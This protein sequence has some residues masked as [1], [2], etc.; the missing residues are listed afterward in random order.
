MSFSNSTKVELSKWKVKSKVEALME[1][2]AIS[3]MNA[4]ITLTNQGVAIRFV[5]ENREVANRISYLIYQI[6]DYSTGLIAKMNDQLQKKPV[7]YVGIEDP[8]VATRFL[9]EAGMNL[10]GKFTARKEV[11]LS[12]IGAEEKAR[13]YLRGAFLGGGSVTNPE[14]GYHLEMVVNDPLDAEILS[15]VARQ[16]GL[17]PKESRRKEMYLVYFK[18]AES[19][20]DFLYIVGATNALL[21]MED[22]R[23]MKNLINDV[24]RR[25]NCDTANLTKAVEASLKHRQAIR[26]IRKSGAFDGL[27]DHLKEIAILREQ[28]PEESLKQLGQHM[29][30]VLGKSGVRNRLNKLMEIA[31]KL[32][33]GQK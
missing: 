8:D 10:Y 20:V 4:T 33:E 14:K 9:E 24:N 1:L 12:R 28:Y 27:P 3:R 29:N 23:A 22:V 32:E 7:Y 11:L 31:E 15:E 26:F 17:K 5:T 19:I 13:A 21:K 30:P 16:V 18:D 6:Y 25:V 2:V